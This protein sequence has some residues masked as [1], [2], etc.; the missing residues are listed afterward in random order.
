MMAFVSGSKK[1]DYALF[2]IML[3]ILLA[4]TYFL[5]VYYIVTV[6]EVKVFYTSPN[7]I[8][9]NLPTP[10]QFKKDPWAAHSPGSVLE[11]LEIRIGEIMFRYEAYLYKNP[12]AQIEWVIK[13]SHNSTKL[14]RT[15]VI[16]FSENSQL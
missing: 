7:G 4:G 5:R 14:D 11:N 15:K 9:E 10:P 3:V 16:K 8:Q 1:F 6:T 2:L 12:G 13:Y